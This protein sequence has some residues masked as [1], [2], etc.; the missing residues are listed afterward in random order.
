MIEFMV[1]S[2]DPRGLVTGQNGDRDIPVGT[3]FTDVRRYRVHKEVGEYHTEDL[4][5]VV[6]VS[7]TLREIHWYR[8]SRDVVPRGHTA[9]L[10]VEG[11]GLEVV[12]RLLHELPLNDFLG[13]V[14]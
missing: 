12:A 8:Q 4:G 3:T 6:G 10:V 1:D 14:A 7:L 11:E 13:L 9:E 2:I 5:V